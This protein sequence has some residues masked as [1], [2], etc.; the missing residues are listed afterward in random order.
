MKIL[1]SFVS[2]LSCFAG[3]KSYNDDFNSINKIEKSNLIND[4]SIRTIKKLKNKSNEN[5]DEI[6][7]EQ[8]SKL[9]K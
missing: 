7:K 4:N 9:S 6:I 3:L 5:F 2:F 1:T 8:I